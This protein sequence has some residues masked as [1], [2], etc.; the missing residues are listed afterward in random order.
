MHTM[1]PVHSH[2]VWSFQ[3][4][5]TQPKVNPH[6]LT[7][8][9]G[10]EVDSHYADPIADLYDDTPLDLRVED[11]TEAKPEPFDLIEEGRTYGGGLEKMEPSELG[12]VPASQLTEL[13]E[14]NAVA[15][16]LYAA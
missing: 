1:P 10:Y 2:A 5:D 4:N 12:N 9:R 3:F 15:T 11:Y 8:A 6:Q 16:W 14:N 13:I 7:V